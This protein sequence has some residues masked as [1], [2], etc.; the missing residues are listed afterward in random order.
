MDCNW[1]DSIVIFLL[2]V[3]LFNK[4]PMPRGCWSCWSYYA[5][6]VRSLQW[7]MSKNSESL[8]FS[9]VLQSHNRKKSQRNRMSRHSLGTITDVACLYRGIVRT[10][11]NWHPLGRRCNPRHYPRQ[12][13]IDVCMIH[14][15]SAV[16]NLWLSAARKNCNT[17][18]K[19]PSRDTDAVDKEKLVNWRSSVLIDA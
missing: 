13:S 16:C 10:L 8:D 15:G 1:A 5:H 11:G 6:C 17:F 4:P 14:V 12:Y 2:V 18:T 9:I 3:C 7:V 19:C